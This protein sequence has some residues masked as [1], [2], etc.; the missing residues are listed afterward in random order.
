VC[1]HALPGASDVYA[2]ATRHAVA[3]WP[4]GV[5]ILCILDLWTEL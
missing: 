2:P 4:I 3:W 5:E 1:V